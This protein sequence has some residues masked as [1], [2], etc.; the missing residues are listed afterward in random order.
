MDFDNR[1]SRQQ[2]EI[3]TIR[4]DLDET[5]TGLDTMALRLLELSAGQEA[6][7]LQTAL[8]S[9]EAENEIPEA[10]TSPAAP[11]DAIAPIQGLERLQS[12]LNEL[13]Q[14]LL[15]SSTH[16][17]RRT[18]ILESQIQELQ[19]SE[20]HLENQLSDLR[21]V[22]STPN[23]SESVVKAPEPVHEKLKALNLQQVRNDQEIRHL[24]KALKRLTVLVAVG[25]LLATGSFL[26]LASHT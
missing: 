3:E 17:E 14:K 18:D 9:I 7:E 12:R 2:K 16:A 6:L 19:H 24:Q 25:G 5:R 23:Q 11:I 15:T 4:V 1:L 22:V 10:S 8:L 20:Q 13:S 21:N 26:W